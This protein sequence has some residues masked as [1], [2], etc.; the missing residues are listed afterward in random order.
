[1][2]IAPVTFRT[3]G[4]V[5]SSA[6]KSAGIEVVI[7]GTSMGWK[8][9]WVTGSPVL[10]FEKP[11]GSLLHMEYPPVPHLACASVSS[12]HPHGA[13]QVIVSGVVAIT[14]GTFIGWIQNWSTGLPFMSFEY[15]HGVFSQRVYP[16]GPQ[17][18]SAVDWS[19]HSHGAWHVTV[20]SEVD[21]AYTALHTAIRSNKIPQIKRRFV[22]F[23]PLRNPFTSLV[24]FTRIMVRVK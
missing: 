24:N 21:A 12:I 19:I 14:T 15:P 20:D 6:G 3:G 18:V 17:L 4:I 22:I 16:F 13:W 7:T 5:V 1:V 8:Q 2:V 23:P 11:H 10:S 9:Y